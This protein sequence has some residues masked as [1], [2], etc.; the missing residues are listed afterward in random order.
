MRWAQTEGQVK[1]ETRTIPSQ[2]MTQ[3]PYAVQL[4]CQVNHGPQDWIRYF[5]PE[6]DT[7]F[8]EVGESDLIE[9]NFQK[10]NTSV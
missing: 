9:A 5:V 1:N 2:V 10:V 3:S 6:V 7:G 4:V 8:L